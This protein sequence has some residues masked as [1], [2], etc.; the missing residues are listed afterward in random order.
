MQGAYGPDSA[1]VG[2][3]QTVSALTGL[4]PS[5]R[6]ARPDAGRHRH[7]LPGPRRRTRPLGV[8]GARRAAP[9][10]PYRRGPVHRPVPGRD[11]GRDCSARRSSTS[12]STATTSSRRAIQR[13]RVAPRRLSVPRRGP[14]DRA[15]ASAPTSSGGNSL[16]ELGARELG[17][18][19]RFAHVR[20]PPAPSRGRLDDRRRR[21]NVGAGRLDADGEP[22]EARCPGR[23]RADLPATWST[24]IRNCVTAVSSPSW[25]IRRWDRRSTTRRRSC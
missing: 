5:V 16:A 11:D 22:A 4:L 13:G 15:R 8:R 14:L 20:R 19:P 10:P 6:S 3:G 18:D 23:C 21:P 2:Y 17:D 12:P 24:T 9:P 25:T 7:Q 1:V